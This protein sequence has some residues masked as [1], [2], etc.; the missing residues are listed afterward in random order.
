MDGSCIPFIYGCTDSLAYNYDPLSNTDDGSCIYAIVD[1]TYCN[2]D[3]NASV[4][5]GSCSGYYGCTDSQ[6]NYD[7]LAG[8]DDGSC[9][10]F[11]YGS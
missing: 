5:D 10:P 8:C 4:D 3:P 6:F 11:I 1:S 2:Y 7:P 9:I